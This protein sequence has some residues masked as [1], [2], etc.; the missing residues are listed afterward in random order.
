MHMHTMLPPFPFTLIKIDGS[1][2][3]NNGDSCSRLYKY[4]SVGLTVF[5]IFLI[6]K[7]AIQYIMERRR[8]WEL[9]SRYVL[10]VLVIVDWKWNTYVNL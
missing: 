1:I 9:Q 2:E 6:A 3:K 5:G 7:H 10:L 4:A 8:R